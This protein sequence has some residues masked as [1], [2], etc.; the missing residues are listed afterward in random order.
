MK[1]IIFKITILFLFGLRVSAQ[2][3]ELPQYINYMADNP[4]L[5][6]PAYAGIGAGFQLRVN[7][8]AQWVGV[9]DSPNTQSVAAEFR[10]ADRFGGGLILFNDKNGFTKQVG[11]RLSFASHITLS[12]YHDSFMSFA[13]S[14][15]FVQFAVDTQNF[16]G[17]TEEELPNIAIGNTNFDIS[18]LYRYERFAISLNIAN[19]LNKPITR[20]DN[21]EPDVLRKYSVYTLYNYKINDSYE[22]EP[23]LHVEYFEGS[24]RSDTDIAVKLRR[25]I[26]DGYLWGGLSYTFLIDQLGE[27]IT[28]APMVGMKKNHIYLAYGVGINLNELTTYNYGTHMITIGFDFN[29]K[30]SLARCTKGMMMF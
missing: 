10:L 13:L 7:G 15:N 30:P 9:K 22:L 29:R 25:R 21:G 18:A 8:V 27:P 4:F 2:E 14:A 24:T 28:L 5:T 11:A 20:V 16:S 17:E 1:K 3:V 12:D 26:R 19:I 23:S 6:S